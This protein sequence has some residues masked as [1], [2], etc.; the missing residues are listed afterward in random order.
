[1]DLV[2]FIYRSNK[3]KN[4][5]ELKDI[6]I[7]F[8]G[9][10]GYNRFIIGELSQDS[11]SEKE[12][13]FGDITNYP[14]EWI[15]RYLKNH[16]VEHDPV[17]LK[18]V[19]ADEPFTWEEARREST[20]KKSEQVMNEAEKYGLCS[21]VGLAI[22]QPLGKIIGFGFSGS[23]KD[24]ECDSDTLSIL[25]AA[26]HQ[27]V[28]VYS[29]LEETAPEEESSIQITSREQEVLNWVARGKTKFEIAHI[30]SISES[31][32]KYHCENLFKKFK[33]NN[34]ISTVVKALRQGLINPY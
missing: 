1:M 29:E 11:L 12:V 28:R 34:L 18:A 14:D 6:W 31:T 22:H 5:E 9:E 24:A 27:F 26:S 15:D 23:D 20:S 21:G 33:T 7:E 16:Y 30:L 32:V 25:H 2:E 8:I 19:R 3:C 4:I 13:N 17:Y 10:F